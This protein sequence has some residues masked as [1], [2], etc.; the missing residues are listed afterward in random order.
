MYNAF[1]LADHELTCTGQSFA[2]P[3][4]SYTSTS[5]NAD[6]DFTGFDF[7][8]LYNSESLV[9]SNYYAP[10]MGF[11][12]QDLPII[13]HPAHNQHSHTHAT[14]PSAEWSSMPPQ[15]PAHA[16]SRPAAAPPA[17]A[18][19]RHHPY[20]AP[21]RAYRQQLARAHSAE[22]PPPPPPLYD[23]TALPASQSM[24]A[25]EQFLAVPAYAHH[26][27]SGPATPTSPATPATPYTPMTPATPYTPTTPHTPYTPESAYAPR[28][29]RIP[30]AFAPS[31]AQ[32]LREYTVR[33]KVG[34]V[35]GFR[36]GDALED[37]GFAVDG[38]GD[39]VLET[40]VDRRG[41][42]HV[43]FPTEDGGLEQ[44]GS[45][46][47]LQDEYTD[48]VR[49]TKAYRRFTRVRFAKEA[50]EAVQRAAHAVQESRN[51]GLRAVEYKDLWITHATRG[52][53]NGWV[54]GLERV[55]WP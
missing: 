39:V 14:T 16:A 27:P 17:R 2:G 21:P 11:V 12:A 22:L 28:R 37:A 25:V 10:Q 20:T 26:A 55:E 51:T 6:F 3:S 13:I 50:A 30:Q 47:N 32:R 36:L 4:T 29:V 42:L 41:H 45:Y 38:G 35:P 9:P 7:S 54:V 33:F 34:G 52:A 5:T 19:H 44:R 43:D 49:G 23:T 31:R 1:H 53:R 48:P 40:C 46:I 18:A 8:S 15:Q 24:S